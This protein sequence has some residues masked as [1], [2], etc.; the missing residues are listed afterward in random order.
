MEDI[1]GGL[2]P[3]L[4]GQSLDEDEDEVTLYLKSQVK[5]GL[6]K[7][8]ENQTNDLTQTDQNQKQTNRIVCLTVLL[9]LQSSERLAAGRSHG[10]N[11]QLLLLRRQLYLWGHFGEIFA[12]VAIV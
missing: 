10:R 11:H 8:Q 12:Y 5:T 1:D 7:T 6:S 4:N 9:V 2:H 3:A